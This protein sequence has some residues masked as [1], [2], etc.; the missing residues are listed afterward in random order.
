[1]L[2]LRSS[3]GAEQEIRRCAVVALGVLQGIAP[4]FFSDFEIYDAEDRRQAARI[5]YHK[6]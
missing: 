1:M 2:E 5:L 3:E 4:G 6:V